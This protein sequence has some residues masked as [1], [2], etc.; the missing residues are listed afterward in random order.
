M[1]ASRQRRLFD[2]TREAEK[3]V[4]FLTMINPGDFAQ[5]LL[6]ILETWHYMLLELEAC[7][8]DS[9][10]DMLMEMV[11]QGVRFL[12]LADVFCQFFFK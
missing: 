2:D 6:P 9:I 10:V 7:Y 4:T 12:P 11:K 5:M 3:V 1:P 8:D